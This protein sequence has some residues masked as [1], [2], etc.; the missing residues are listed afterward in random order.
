MYYWIYDNIIAILKNVIAQVQ[1]QFVVLT[2][3]N[4]SNERI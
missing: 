1:A 2:F 4:I 3:Q